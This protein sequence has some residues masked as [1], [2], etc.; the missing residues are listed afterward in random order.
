MA[1]LVEKIK[2]AAGLQYRYAPESFGA[3]G[4]MLSKDEP[5]PSAGIKMQKLMPYPL[6]KRCANRDRDIRL[7]Q[8]ELIGSLHDPTCIQSLSETLNETVNTTPVILHLS[9]VD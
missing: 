7:M 2:N 3:A 9:Y 5:S 6:V 1:P 8:N 4:A